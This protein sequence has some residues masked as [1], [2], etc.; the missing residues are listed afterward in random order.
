MKTKD[1]Q[2][3]ITTD[4]VVNHTYEVV[5]AAVDITG[6]V[7][8]DEDSPKDVITIKGKLTAPGEGSALTANASF[9]NIFLDWT[10]PADAD[11]DVMEVWR[12]TTNNRSNAS[13]IAAVRSDHYADNLGAADLTRYYWIRAKNTSGEVSD[14]YPV[15]ATAGVSATTGAVVATDIADFAITASKLF[16]KIPVLDADSWSDDTPG[17]GSITWNEHNLYYNGVLHVVATGNTALHYVYWELSAPT[18]YQT[19]DTEPT[20]TDTL[21]IIAVNVSGT[22]NV[23]W[24]S[25][26]NQVVGSAYIKDLAVVRA[27]IALLAVDTAQIAALAVETGKINNLAVTNAKINTMTASKLTAGTIDASVITVTNLNATNMTAGTLTSRTV[28]TAASG[29]RIV[30]NQADNT[31]KLYVGAGAGSVVVTIDDNIFGSVPGI[32]LVDGTDAVYLTPTGIYMVKASATGL[33]DASLHIRD[34]YGGVN[35]SIE[36]MQGSTE[37]FLVYSDG[38][39]MIASTLTISDD[40]NMV[41]GK[42]VDGIDVS[43]FK[44]AYDIHTHT[45]ASLTS[46]PTT[47][48]GYGIT[49]AAPLSHVG[50]GGTGLGVHAVVTTSWPGFMSGTDKIKLNG[51]ANGAQPGT[52]TAVTGSAPV[53]SSGGTTPAI[54][55]LSA[56]AARHGYMTLTYASKLDGIATGA[57]VTGNN[58]PQAHKASHQNGGGDEIDVVGL[59]GLLA[60]DQ[61]PRVHNASKITTGQLLTARGGTNQG[62]W[63]QQ[64]VVVVELGGTQL[65]S[66][67]ITT[68]ELG[69]L[70]NLAENV[71]ARFNTLGTIA[72]K[73]TGTTE[74]FSVTGVQFIFTDGIYQGHV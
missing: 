19:S 14:Y 15:S 10:N 11:F 12:S 16:L 41:A 51:I 23:A 9:Y 60:D 32:G 21:F 50:A 25:I 2:I 44:S 8:V 66:S 68:T 13:L 24:N 33:A 40:I 47:L 57:N 52:V 27:K 42:T 58:A 74:T 69:Y 5:V 65:K 4:L 36:V 17:A 29:Q 56:T 43:A 70:N 3:E 48:A 53:A 72:T 18:V 63:T 37:K 71:Q 64:T 38:A 59:S 55:M 6:R 28:Q 30:L 46:K 67:S 39:V 20:Q 35:T 26:A 31:M 54:S 49:D 34:N 7:Q 1:R 61:T 62:S 45:F 73:A 22:H